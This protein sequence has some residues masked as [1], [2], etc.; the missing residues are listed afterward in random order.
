M[1]GELGVGIETYFLWEKDQTLPVVRYYPA[2][3]GFLGYDPF[4]PPTTLPERIAAQRRRLGLTIKK[5]AEK[6]GV[7]EGTFAQW[8]R[9]T[10]KPR[11]SGKVVQ[12]F[13]ALPAPNG[14]QVSGKRAT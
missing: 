14:P 8:E 3:F 10:W 6:A 4:P 13:L 12:G 9:G 7:D 1:A 2:I 5:A 11:L